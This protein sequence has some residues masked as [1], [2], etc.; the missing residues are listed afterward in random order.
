MIYLLWGDGHSISQN[1]E[2]R[3]TLTEIE[4]KH[5]IILQIGGRKY[6]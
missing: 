2:K 3:K 4:E 5:M 1:T 6:A